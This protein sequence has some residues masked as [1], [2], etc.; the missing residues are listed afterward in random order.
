MDRRAA[1]AT[2]LSA[3]LL[4][5]S[6]SIA[7]PPAANAVDSSSPFSLSS[8]I[9]TGSM[10]ATPSSNPITIGESSATY[11]SPKLSS[12]IDSGSV[13]TPTIAITDATV[14]PAQSL[15]SLID[16]GSIKTSS[17]PISNINPRAIVTIRLDSPRKYAGLE[18]YDV[19]IGTPSRNVVAVRSVRPDGE[20]GRAGAERGMILLDYTDAKS[21]VKRIAGPYPLELRLYNLAL[22][23][24]GI[25]D[26]GRGIVTAEDALELAA[27][28]T[29]SGTGISKGGSNADKEKKFGEGAFGR[30]NANVNEAAAAKSSEG[31]VI[32]TVR[33]AKGKC[34]MQSRRGDTMQI[35]YEARVDD[36]FGP[37]YDSSEFRGTGQPYA[38]MLG[39]N[40]VIKGVD[41]GT[42][43]MCPGE[44]R[45][46]TI[47]PE[48]GYGGRGSK[49]FKIGPNKRL[50]W[51][52]QLVELNF[53]KEGEN[54]NPRDELY[55]GLTK[56]P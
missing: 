46:L 40:D 4:L 33:P 25:G 11:S 47:P 45:E 34:G 28:T 32:D 35:R 39:N 38:Y 2:V 52:V 50:W 10:K 15:S 27:S 23:G 37:V 22:G 51:R 43:D 30:S 19:K 31:F 53:I 17:T 20:G 56:P 13:H 42:Y 18:L 3:P 48:L 16:A 41:L 21:V 44:V 8:L 12:L 26:L 6:S 14:P 1:T 7:P 54:D 29:S 49:L 36:Q 24:D 9:D 55:E 5:L